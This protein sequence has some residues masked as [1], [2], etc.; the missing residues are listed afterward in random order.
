MTDWSVISAFVM[1]E[2]PV[3]PVRRRRKDARPAELLQAAL[4]VFPER[5]FSAAK[6]D[7]LGLFRGDTGK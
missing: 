7:E 6:M 3:R 5:G 4:S 2:P 1:A